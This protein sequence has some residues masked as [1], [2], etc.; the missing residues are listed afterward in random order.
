[1]D[2]VPVQLEDVAS[3]NLP[4]ESARDGP[5]L[6]SILIPHALLDFLHEPAFILDA[7]HRITFLNRAAASDYDIS[8]TEAAGL[9]FSDVTGIAWPPSPGYIAELQDQWRGWLPRVGNELSSRADVTVYTLRGSDDHHRY[10]VFIHD[11]VEAV[12]RLPVAD[13]ERLH[14]LVYEFSTQFSRLSEDE[15]DDCIRTGLQRLVA[16]VGVEWSS[17]A[18]LEADDTLRVT[19]SYAVAGIQPYPPGHAEK[20]FPWLTAELRTGRTIVAARIPEDLPGHAVH[21][22]TSLADAGVKSGVAIPLHLGRGQ[23]FVLALGSLASC[24]EWPPDL[25]DGLRVAGEIFANAVA[26][27]QA[28]ERLQAKQQELAHLGRVVAVSEL[29]SVLAHEL[30]QP[31]TA[32]ITNAQAA[33]N[34]LAL[35]QPDLAESNSALADIIADSVRA[36]QIVQRERRLLRKG[37]ANVEP[38]DLDQ[39]VD[40]IGLFIRADGRQHRCACTIELSALP[41]KIRGDRVQLQ[42]VLLNLV[43][44]GI[45]AMSQQ[46][47]ER[48]VLR[49]STRG[50][51]NDAVIDVSDAGPAISD[52]HLQQVF[53]SFFTTKSDGLGMG[54]SISQSIVQ[55]H[56]GRIWV[57]RNP[58]AG[59]T[60]HVA[61]PRVGEVQHVSQ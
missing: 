26:R 6:T 12:V 51:G 15:V 53:D 35:P 33:R 50:D 16:F 4:R 39:V 40:E 18:E 3:T 55:A 54:L 58:D 45:Q 43:R 24:R 59:L 20:R 19:H 17:F 27:R 49:V 13:R 2:A 52:K 29:A 36:S 60:F 37:Q 7:N 48:R 25:L 44:N 10:A 34:L 8:V 14:A 38:L 46:P 61:I 23:C 5:V 41:L 32:I 30:D 9:I 21:D 22:A 28:K 31:L 11:K 1:M 57:S 42:Q 56:G 47:R